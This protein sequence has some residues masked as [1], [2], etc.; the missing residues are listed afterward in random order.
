M[1]SLADAVPSQTG[2][3]GLWRLIRRA[4]WL[5][6]AGFGG[7]FAI[8][9][10]L[11]RALV[12]KERRLQDQEFLE[13]FAVA[14]ALPGTTAANL[15]TIIGVRLGGI[16]GGMLS[17]TA[18]LLPSVLVMIAFGSI[19][20]HVRKI[21]ALGVFLDGMG[22]A[23]VGVVAAVATDIGRTSLAHRRDWLFATL[24]ATAL[25]AHAL[26]LLEVVVLAG[27][28]GAWCRRPEAAHPSDPTQSGIAPSR[29]GSFMLPLPLVAIAATPT[30]ILLVSFARIG[31]ATFGGGF[32]MIPAIEHEIVATRHWLS[33]A[34][35][36][37]AIVLGQ[38][39]PGPVAT[40]ATF[41]GYRVA[42]V[43]GALCATLGMFAPP[44]VLSLLAGRSLQSFH[45]NPL[46]Q[47][48]LR[49]ITPAMSGILAAAA[50][51]LW[52]TSVHGVAPALV[53]VVAAAILIKWRV[54]PLF[55]LVAGG[56]A[57][58]AIAHAS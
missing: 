46:V 53:A 16:T 3:R 15:L 24:A 20:N 1:P 2:S 12:E 22:V 52:R 51:A 38:I 9:Q 25:V 45:A 37:D 43:A 4:F 47:G 27:F 34:A 36:N 57:L 8:A 48:A 7:G 55:V 42:G 44:L 5:G 17:A 32:A 10:Q 35:F 26:T 6:V 33:E 13:S 41:I 29:L 39:T 28:C 18:F 21:T 49:G 31:L 54:A 40:A 50:V 30:V 23:T 14:T 11:R 19:Y 58:L 56:V